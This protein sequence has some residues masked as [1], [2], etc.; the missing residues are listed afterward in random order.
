MIGSTYPSEIRIYKDEETGRE[1][2]QLTQGPYENYH[3]YFT[4]NSFTLGD[5]EI[6]FLSNRPY[7][8]TEIF[9]LCRMD[10]ESGV[11]TQLTDE[12]EG[13]QTLN[14]TKSP[15][16]SVCIYIV[17]RQLKKLDTKTGEISVIYEAAQGETIGS[18]FVSPDM[19]CVGIIRTE[20][21]G[22]YRNA[23]NY[24]GFSENFYD[25]KR[26]WVE[27]VA[28]DGSGSRTIVRDTCWC[29]HF[30]FSPM[31]PNVALFC[32]EGP[33]NL[34]NQRMYLVD[35]T[36]Q[37][38]TPCF[39]Q[40]KDDCIGHEFWTRDGL[41][42]FDNRGKGHDG[43]I[44]SDRSQIYD[45]EVDD[46][47]AYIGLADAAG[48]ILKTIPMPYYCNHYHANNDNTLLVGDQTDHLVI[49][50]IHDEANPTIRTL[51]NHGTSW[52]YQRCHCHPTFSW[53]CDQIL[54]TSDRDG[55]CNIYSIGYE[56]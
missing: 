40:E 46:S 8:G 43:T 12:Q 38:I 36:T 31:D 22:D 24:G 50:D 48:K 18:P 47:H 33:W 25:V 30:Q 19:K 2:R 3:L 54:Y 28:L 35:C 11:I 42:F 53:S 21:L 41:I 15:D 37:E 27:L 14:H 39:R 6:Y 17:G 7:A 20:D 29:N 45:G 49:I 44:T 13:I 56:A 52:K 4:D 23:A 5:R 9:N 16:S 55:V 1:I 10:L 34:V 26:S 51:C 32:H